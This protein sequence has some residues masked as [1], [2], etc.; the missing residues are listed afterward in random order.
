MFDTGKV[1][2]NLSSYEEYPGTFLFYGL[3]FQIFPSYF[4]MKFLPPI[5]YILGV[6]AIYLMFKHFFD[7]KISFLVSV[8]YLFFNWTVEDNHLSPQFLIFNLYLVFILILIKFFSSSKKDR[9]PYLFYL[10]LMIPVIVFSHPGTPIFLILILGSMFIIC[11]RVRSLEFFSVILF[12]VIIFATYMYYQS[13]YLDSYKTYIKHFFDIL[14]SG[15]F[16]GTSQ[17]FVTTLSS[18]IIFLDSRMTITVFSFIIGMAGILLL[19]KRKYK[20][21]S[22]L[23]IGW[24][25]SMLF[26]TIFVSISLRG[27]YYERLILIASLPLAAVGAY[28]LKEFK[29]PGIIILVLLLVLTPLYFVAKYGNEA[30]ESMSLEKLKAECFSYNFYDN[31]D[32]KQE[33]IE[34]EFGYNFKLHYYSHLTVTRENILS[35]S[36]YDNMSQQNVK[37]KLER[38]I[39]DRKL[40]K[41]YSSNN[42]AS[43]V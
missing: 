33:I 39:L 6:I 30:F 38:I 4:F 36:I 43:Y 8:L 17:R 37:I 26:F 25:L 20:A 23:F 32:Q 27:E 40:D 42:A 41:I 35:T 21:E 5:V 13:I 3:L 29:V 24:I 15:K 28:F 34:T 14:Q 22:S 12:L 18:R 7:A 9:I 10:F 1:V 19:L 16:S 11:K 2:N 31:C